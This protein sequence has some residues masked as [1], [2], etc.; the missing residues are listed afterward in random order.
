[1][2]KKIRK[3]SE[4]LNKREKKYNSYLKDKKN[5][6]KFIENER[7]QDIID[8]HKRKLLYEKIA[9]NYNKKINLSNKINTQT[10]EKMEELKEQIKDYEK[11]KST[12]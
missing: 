3:V 6:M 7:Y 12:I 2:E 5:G 1:M 4:K 10:N 9:S 8:M 11:K